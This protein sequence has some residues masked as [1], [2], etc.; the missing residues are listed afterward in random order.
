MKIGEGL[1]MCLTMLETSMTDDDDAS[2]V[3]GMPYT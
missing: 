1:V 3:G 2:P